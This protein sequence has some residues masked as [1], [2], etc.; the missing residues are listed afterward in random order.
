MFNIIDQLTLYDELSGTLGD[1]VLQV[2][3]NGFAQGKKILSDGF[4]PC[5]LVIVALKNGEFA[6]FHALSMCFT[7]NTHILKVCDEKPNDNAI[8]EEILYVYKNEK[9]SSLEYAVK[10]NDEIIRKLIDKDKIKLE[11]FDDL[12]K[13]ADPLQLDRNYNEYSDIF[14]DEKYTIFNKMSNFIMSINK[15]DIKEII[16]FEHLSNET[17][18]RKGPSLAFN[19]TEGF[20]FPVKRI[21]VESYK[22]VIINHDEI[23][24]FNKSKY[25]YDPNKQTELKKEKKI[26]EKPIIYDFEDSFF[27][28]TIQYKLKKNI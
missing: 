8:K 24:L 3:V 16:V 21:R 10:Q 13:Y 22:G 17:N 15:D 12:K 14:Y 23:T 27:Q 7:H 28:F 2:G 18:L 5:Q 6:L 20:D 26:E 4:G 11:D 25:K 19:L 9:A 1:D